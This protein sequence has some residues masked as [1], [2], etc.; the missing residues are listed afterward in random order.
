VA[1]GRLKG[2]EAL[3]ARMTLH[4]PQLNLSYEIDGAVEL[5]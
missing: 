4:I 2:H 3:P 5:E 1:E